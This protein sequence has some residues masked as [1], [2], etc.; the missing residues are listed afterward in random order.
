MVLII[1]E[2]PDTDLFEKLQEEYEGY[3]KLVVDIEKQAIAGGGKFHIDC[4][5]ALIDEG[6]KLENL[7]G[8]GYDVVSKKVD[9]FAMS[10]YK[11]SQG[12]VT[13]EIADQE[14]R[15]KFLSIVKKYFEVGDDR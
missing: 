4:E 13:Y 2:N 5:E 14:I 8:G 3:I 15:S 12:H 7:Y 10:N 9:Y 1:N 11:P 6:S